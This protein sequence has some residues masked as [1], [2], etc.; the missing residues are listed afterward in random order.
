MGQDQNENRGQKSGSNSN[1][2]AQ[3]GQKK[4]T[5][6]NNPTAK[7]GTQ[8]GSQ[9]GNQQSSGTGNQQGSQGGNQRSQGSGNAQGKTNTGVDDAAELNDEDSDEE[10]AREGK[11]AEGDSKRQER[12]SGQ[13]SKGNM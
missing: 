2:Q 1:Q 10:T 12:S 5:N 4:E 6:P 8:Q 11:S 3:D 7:M 9:S 13:G